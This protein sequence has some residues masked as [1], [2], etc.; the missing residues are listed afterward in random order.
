VTA[1]GSSSVEWSATDPK[2]A[3]AAGASHRYRL[4]NGRG[5][6]DQEFGNRGQAKSGVDE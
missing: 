1:P 6:N 4:V 3:R 5:K 2:V